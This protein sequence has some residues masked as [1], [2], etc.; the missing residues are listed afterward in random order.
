MC[1]SEGEMKRASFYFLILWGDVSEWVVAL[2]GL[3]TILQKNK[4]HKLW[5]PGWTNSPR[6]LPLSS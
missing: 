1:K 4:R 3:C 2:A 5:V 6:S